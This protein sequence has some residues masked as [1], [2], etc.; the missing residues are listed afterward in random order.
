[1]GNSRPTYDLIL[2]N[3]HY[4]IERHGSGKITKNI[5]FTSVLLNEIK[6][7]APGH[8]ITVWDMTRDKITRFL[9]TTH[10]SGKDPI[11]ICVMPD[12]KLRVLQIVSVDGD[13]TCFYHAVMKKI[14]G[15]T[16]KETPRQ[17]QIRVMKSIL[18]K[19][20]N[21]Y[22]RIQSTEKDDMQRKIKF[23]DYSMMLIGDRIS[24]MNLNE[25]P[26]PETIIR[27]YALRI[28]GVE[29]A[30]PSGMLNECAWADSPEIQETAEVIGHP[31]WILDMG[32]TTRVTRHNPT[33]VYKNDPILLLRKG[34]HF[35]YM[36]VFEPGTQNFSNGN[37]M[38][39]SIPEEI[40]SH[41]ETFYEI[42]S[43]VPEV[44]KV[45]DALPKTRR[46][47]VVKQRQRRQYQYVTFGTRDRAKSQSSNGP[48]TMN[49]EPRSLPS[50]TSNTSNTSNTP[51]TS[52]ANN[53]IFMNSGD[54]TPKRTARSKDAM[55]V[56]ERMARMEETLLELAAKPDPIPADMR[57][58]DIDGHELAREMIQYLEKHDPQKIDRLVE[59]AHSNP[60][61]FTKMKKYVGKGLR[62]TGRVAGNASMGEWA[63]SGSVLI[64][65]SVVATVYGS[66][67]RV[68][69]A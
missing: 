56:A 60:G 6:H 32:N 9:D 39:V 40:K 42:E 61:F 67:Y 5:G 58:L 7:V 18:Q 19:A 17:L 47:R 36:Q 55:E 43:L 12:G 21:A 45:K 23:G 22:E 2:T 51:N 29:K 59:I 34:K 14:P 66:W 24:N 54:G 62:H 8:P 1:M 69:Y 57:R 44:T 11:Y 20:R 37:A 41:A 15:G 38:S 50:I 64:L 10:R 35:S 46:R 53:A 31:I 3:V 48:K 52:N 25:F 30:G 26:D 4:V 27:D 63:M 28:S 49:Y 33:S 65:S 68:F 13:G 16:R